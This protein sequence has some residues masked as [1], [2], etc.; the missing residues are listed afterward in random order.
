MSLICVYLLIV[1]NFLLFFF[2]KCKKSLRT[3]VPLKK[4]GALTRNK[5]PVPC[6]Y[7]CKCTTRHILIQSHTN[8]EVINLLMASRQQINHPAEKT[9]PQNSTSYSPKRRKAIPPSTTVYLPRP[10]AQFV[11]PTASTPA[12]GAGESGWSA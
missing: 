6:F 4:D 9:R 12:L 10:F 8:L 2:Q 7:A 5:S 11:F 1:D 3:Q